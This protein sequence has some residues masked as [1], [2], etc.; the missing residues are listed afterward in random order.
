MYQIFFSNELYRSKLFELVKKNKDKVL[1]ASIKIAKQYGYQVLFTSSYYC[2][3][4]LI[5]SI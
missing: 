3:L 2:K 1:F 4:Q 5:E